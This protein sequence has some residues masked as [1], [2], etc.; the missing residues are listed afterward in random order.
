MTPL[1]AKWLPRMPKGQYSGRQARALPQAAVKRAG[2]L[3]LNGGRITM[4]AA[5]IERELPTQFG[6][7]NNSLICTEHRRFYDGASSTPTAPVFEAPLRLMQTVQ[8]RVPSGNSSQRFLATF[9]I[10]R[11]T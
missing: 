9:K 11:S 3:A 6:A 8:V 7:G 1:K 5:I 4:S 10:W 2:E